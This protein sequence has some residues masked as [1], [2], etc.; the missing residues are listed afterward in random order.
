M[1][2]IILSV[3]CASIG[4]GFACCYFICLFYPGLYVFMYIPE[5]FIE[6]Y[7]VFCFFALTNYYVGGPNKAIEIIA[8][9]EAT[10]PN[11]CFKWMNTS[12]KLFYSYAYWAHWQFLFLRPLVVIISVIF[13]YLGQTS[14]VFLILYN[15]FNFLGC[16]M[17]MWAVTGLF[18]MYHV[19]YP[20]CSGLN[21]TWKVMI[22][23][24]TVGIILSEGLFEQLSYQFGWLKI[25]GG[26]K[27]YDEAD[28]D[29]R[30]YCSVVLVQLVLISF[31]LERA[32]TF[33][34]DISKGPN[35]TL[36]N[37][38]SSEIASTNGDST[39]TFNSFIRHCL[40]VNDVFKDVK[41]KEENSIEILPLPK[42]DSSNQ[43]VDN[44]DNSQV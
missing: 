22:I 9:S 1:R 8:T 29:V 37:Y 44:T 23:K 19:L 24:F 25:T 5:A 38:E 17:V 16:L 14:E 42:V 15:S 3:R 20:Y 12:P 28:K 32:F 30:L 2:L 7:A 11:Y 6:A 34:I 4:V 21:A 26:L 36:I 13:Y 31:V 10:F 18:K 40:N 35:A 27:I 41:L 39:L 33:D 43:I